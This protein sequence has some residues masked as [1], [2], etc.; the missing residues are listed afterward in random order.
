[1]RV[2]SWVATFEVPQW[3]IP[4]PLLTPI[5]ANDSPSAANPPNTKMH[6]NYTNP[7]PEYKDTGASLSTVNKELQDNN[8]LFQT[9]SL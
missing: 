3:S 2:D 8:G 1:M 6:A 7:P 9:S 5:Y 4:R